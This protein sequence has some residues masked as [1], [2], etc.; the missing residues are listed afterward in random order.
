VGGFCCV[1]SRRSCR[2]FAWRPLVASRS[3]VICQPWFRGWSC[4]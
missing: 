4:H 2:F 3:R 1:F